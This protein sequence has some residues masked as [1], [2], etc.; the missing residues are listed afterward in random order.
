MDARTLEF[1]AL[2]IVS[3]LSIAAGY[4][5][6]ER[7]WLHED[8]SRKV[9]WVTIVILWSSAGFLALW[10]LDPDP[11]NL[12]VLAIEPLLVIIPAFLI[13]P[14]AKAIKLKRNQVGVLALA[15]G[16]RNSGFALGA[17]LAY[18][19]LPAGE[20]LRQQAGPDGTL[21]PDKADKLS[22]SALAY[23]LLIVMTMSMAVVIFLFPMVQHFASDEEDKQPIGR[24]IY[25]SF[26][27]WKAMLFY[28]SAA[29]IT[30]AYLHVPVPPAVKDWHIMKA[31]IFVGSATAYFG[32][33][34]RL[35]LDQIRP[36]IRSHAILG[37]VKFIATPLL[38]IGLLLIARN[39]GTAPPPAMLDQTF[40]LIAFMPTAIQTV[41]V[42]NLFHLDA[43]MAGSVWIINT[44]IFICLVLPMILL[45][46][47]RL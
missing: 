18:A 30:L 38:T 34:M 5:S 40:I 3:A 15:A 31:L 22:I 35:H 47:A 21:A 27:D 2:A 17:F 9:H 36:H 7:G 23:G 26:V 14:L 19:I 41:I 8:V 29:G 4:I 25:K 46:T 42:A 10:H 11:A 44:L 43:R 45:V 33:G 28:S 39:L 24:I 6:R 32:I 1:F 37:A 13:I 16:L 20:F 12:W